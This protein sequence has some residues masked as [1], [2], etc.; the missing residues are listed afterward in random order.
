[1]SE[2]EKRA[3]IEAFNFVRRIKGNRSN[4]TSVVPLVCAVEAYDAE[5]LTGL[6]PRCDADRLGIPYPFKHLCADGGA[7]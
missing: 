4:P 7:K 3:F 1:M 5:N 6:C 2:S